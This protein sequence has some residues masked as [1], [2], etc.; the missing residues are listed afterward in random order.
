MNGRETTIPAGSSH[1]EEFSY[2]PETDTLTIVF[3]G[4]D[5]YDYMNVPIQL[6]REF[7]QAP[8]AGQFFYR[9][10]KNRFSYDGPK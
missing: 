4:G 5:E 3:D 7:Q 1:I 8:S 2:D 6:Y 9:R 10:I